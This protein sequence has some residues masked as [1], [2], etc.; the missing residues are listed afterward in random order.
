[1]SRRKGNGMQRTRI[2]EAA[3][4]VLFLSAAALAAQEEAPR[5]ILTFGP[6]LG[7]SAVLQEPGS[8]SSDMRTLLY[9]SSRDF[10]PV[11]TELGIQA[12]Q[13]L[14]LGGS[15][16][17]FLFQ[18]TLLVGGLEQRMPLPSLSVTLGCRLPFGLELGIG[19]Y[20]T[21]VPGDPG[22]TVSMVYAVGWTF[23]MQDFQ[24]PLMLTFVPIPSYSS[25]RLSL[26]SGLNFGSLR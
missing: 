10:F 15:G 6:R 12:Q 2:I 19:P 24:V 4:V 26:L 9:D 23:A 1:M 17:F 22:F 18:Q 21:I 7:V 16:A 3:V 8:F 13:A 25:P 14:P 11:F 5:S 20:A